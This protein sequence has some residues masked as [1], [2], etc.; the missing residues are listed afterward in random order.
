MA[1]EQRDYYEVL[2]VERTATQEEI[3]RAY[4]K[5]AMKY[6]P[7][8]NHGNKDAEE[9]FK[10]VGEAYSIL[11]DEDKRAAYDRYGHSAFGA[12]GPGAGGFGGFG[13]FSQADFGN[14]G[15]I[16]ADIFGAATGTTRR[17]AEGNKQMFRGDDLAYNLEIT[18]EQAAEGFKSRIKVPKWSKCEACNGTGAE[19]GTH[20]ETCP[21]CG[22]SGFVRSGQGFFTVQRTCPECRGTGKVIRHPCHECH[23]TGVVEGKQTLEVNIPAGVFDGARIRV[24]GKG[25]PGQNGGPNGDLY[26]QIQIK[27]HDVFE[28]DGMDLHMQMPMSFVTAALGGELEVPTLEG[29]AV[30]RIPA[31]TQPGKIF[32]LKDR[33]IKNLRGPDKG[34]LYV[35]VTVEVPVNMDKEQEDLLRKFDA[36]LNSGGVN[37]H[38]PEKQGFFDK[39][40]NLFK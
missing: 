32:R 15:D 19:K 22:G 37:H 36:S 25:G 1:E 28:R 12:G 3:K 24:P 4:R 40:S 39:L 16:F 29:K 6:H 34:D 27:P 21:M 20:P 14:M 18:L 2:G 5:L 30:L 8:R 23:G 35:H 11:G 17:S 33:G 9:K 26:V 7:D 38:A 10:Q 13:G 31:G